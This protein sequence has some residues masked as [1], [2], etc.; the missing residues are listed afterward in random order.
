M[1]TETHWRGLDSDGRSTFECLL[2]YENDTGGVET[3]M[4]AP[5]NSCGPTTHHPFPSRRRRAHSV[6]PDRV[7]R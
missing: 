5:G 4:K 1:D 6:H 2:V 7:G 3:N